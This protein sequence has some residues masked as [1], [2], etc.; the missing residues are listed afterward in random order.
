MKI[1]R[2]F[3]SGE[4]GEARGGLAVVDEQLHLSAIHKH[5]HGDRPIHSRHGNGAAAS[6]IVGALF[7]GGEFVHSGL[8]ALDTG[9]VGER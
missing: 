7:V 6:V 8:F 9:S 2:F 1:A 4:N 5:A 3:G